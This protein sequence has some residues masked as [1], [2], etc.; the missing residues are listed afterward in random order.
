MYVLCSKRDGE[1]DCGAEKVILIDD[2]PD[3]SYLLLVQFPQ[4]VTYQ[5]PEGKRVVH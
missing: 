4:L 1:E 3:V 5:G 2:T